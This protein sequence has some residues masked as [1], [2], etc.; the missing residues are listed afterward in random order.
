MRLL[1]RCCAVARC[2]FIRQLAYDLTSFL[3]LLVAYTNFREVRFVGRWCG[4][5]DKIMIITLSV[6]LLRFYKGV[7]V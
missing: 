3:F 4:R 2:H 7:P 6:C 5:N 1:S